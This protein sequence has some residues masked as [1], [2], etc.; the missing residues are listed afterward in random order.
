M[1]NAIY[2]LN[3]RPE[4][5]VRMAEI[6]Q[7]AAKPLAAARE[8][9]LRWWFYRMIYDPAEITR[10]AIGACRHCHGDGFGYQ[11]REHEYFKA[12]EE[13]ELA[14]MPLPDIGGG[15]GYNSTR[16]PV[17]DC[18]NCDGR[19]L[20]RTNIADT[21]QLSPQARAAFEGIKQTK[22]GIEIRMADKNRAAEQFAKLSGFDVVQIRHLTDVPDTAELA[23][24]ATD[25]I[26][27]SA[28]YKRLMGATTH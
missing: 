13:A 1:H 2:A 27:A 22:D 12:I 24:L 10:W 19:G 14:K 17:P 15:F 7:E 4:I 28:A 26:A 6:Q 9:L 20:G 21:S 18:P 23:M 5:I 8:W 3:G 16:P 25:P 11:W